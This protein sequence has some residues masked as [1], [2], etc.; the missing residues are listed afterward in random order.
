MWLLDTRW[1]SQ[2]LFLVLVWST[3]IV[4]ILFW[5]GITIWG[6]GSWSIHVHPITVGFSC[7]PSH[8]TFASTPVQMHSADRDDITGDTAEQ[9][10]TS[11]VGPSRGNR[12]DKP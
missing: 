10:A 6:T 5:I 7:P 2:F 12:V 4:N 9:A 3:L 8:F 11:Y 1:L